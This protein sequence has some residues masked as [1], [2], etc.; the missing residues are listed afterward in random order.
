M[1]VL[2]GGERMARYESRQV[3]ANITLDTLF[4]RPDDWTTVQHW[5]QSPLLRRVR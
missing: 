2:V 5:Y 1:D 3:R 4:F